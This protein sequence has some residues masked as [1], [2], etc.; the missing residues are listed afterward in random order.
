MAT[1]TE[2]KNF[3]AKYSSYAQKA[4]ATLGI[5]QQYILAQWALETGY[6]TKFAGK[7]NLGN[8]QG[9][10]PKP[11]DYT[12]YEQGVG[13]YVSTLQNKRYTSALAAR[14]PVTFGVELKK[15]GYATDPY[16]AYK[17]ASTIN[18]LGKFKIGAG[19][20]GMDTGVVTTPDGQVVPTSEGGIWANLTDF[21]KL[22]RLIVSPAFVVAG[23]IGLFL[24]FKNYGMGKND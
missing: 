24:V 4:S 20:I 9:N 3:V 19:D 17:I 14:D 5:P 7:Y 1:L 12:S 21:G 16:Y 8:V 15:A 6:G 13:A 23:A 10:N 22:G 2:Q 11:Y 18:S